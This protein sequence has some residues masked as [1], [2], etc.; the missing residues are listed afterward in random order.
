MH[1]RAGA[2]H[3]R[4]DRTD[5]TSVAREEGTNTPTS[6]GAYASTSKGTYT[7]KRTYTANHAF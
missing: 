2:C 6:E 4:Q 7:S 1:V 5:A 3:A